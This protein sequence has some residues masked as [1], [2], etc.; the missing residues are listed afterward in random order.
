MSSLK[1]DPFDIATSVPLITGGGSGIGFGLLEQ[2]LRLGCTKVLITGRRKHILQQAAAKYPNKVHYLVSDAGS[3]SDREALLR[4][5][6]ENH[7]DCNALINNAGIQRR[8]PLVEETTQ[9]TAERAAEI[10]INLSGPIH[11]CSLFIPLLLKAPQKQAMIANVSSGLAFIPFVGGPTYAATKAGLHSYTMALRW[12]LEDTGKLRVV[13]I[14]PP[15]TKSN[16]GGG[17]DFGEECEDVCKAVVEGMAN[18]MLEVGYGMAD[19]WRLV[20]D[21]DAVEANMRGVGEWVHVP[22]WS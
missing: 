20:G 17:H 7:P 18:G 13:E 1:T 16:L 10:E 6:T 2:F 9:W 15:A 4:W 5:V 12:T 22:K 8:V 3:A 21:R 14:V 19:Q 11:L